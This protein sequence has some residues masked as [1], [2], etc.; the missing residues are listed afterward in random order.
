VA[1]GPWAEGEPAGLGL[2]GLTP[3][4][5]DES[6]VSSFL[7][8]SAAPFSF[9]K[10]ASG[11]WRPDNVTATGAAPASIRVPAGRYDAYLVR[12]GPV[13]EAPSVRVLRSASVTVREGG[14]ATVSF[15]GSA[16]RPEG[17]A[18]LEGR[19]PPPRAT[20]GELRRAGTLA[21]LHALLA[22]RVD[23]EDAQ[24]RWAAAAFAAFSLDD[25]RRLERALDSGAEGSV[26]GV[27][28]AAPR[29]FR[30]PGLAPGRYRATARGRGY[31]AWTADVA[32]GET[33]ARLDLGASGGRLV[34][35]GGR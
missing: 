33:G 23:L 17:A 34:P 15:D 6:R 3:G 11:A 4:P 35:G 13:F 8:D 27:L 5:L 14:A 28:G 25:L 26:S 32:L 22:P 19:L 20:L 16:A 7:F 1:T 18:A 30:I 29:P 31:S 24:G 21:E 12:T 10:G 9:R 2:Y